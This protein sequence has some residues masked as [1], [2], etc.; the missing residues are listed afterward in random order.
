M[1]SLS[2]LLPEGP[3]VRPCD[4]SQALN[5][6]LYVVNKWIREG[7]LPRPA[8]RPTRKVILLDRQEVIDALEKLTVEQGGAA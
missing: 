4:I 1:A 6:K 3:Y 7:V 8:L 5:V 2:M